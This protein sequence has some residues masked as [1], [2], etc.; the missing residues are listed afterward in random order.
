MKAIAGS[1]TI[2]AAALMIA[3]VPVFA[4]EGVMSQQEPQ[5]QKNECLLVAKNCAPNTIQER[6]QSIQNEIG[7]GT[8]VYSNDELKRLNQQLE[9][10]QKFLDYE[11]TNSGA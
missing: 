7:K 4:E 9:D 8:A 2:V 10:A 11:L 3:A 5:V 1:L 6:I